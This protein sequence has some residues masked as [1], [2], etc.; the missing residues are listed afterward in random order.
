MNARA[1]APPP[2]LSRIRTR[3][4]TI[5]VL[6]SGVAAALGMAD[7]A[8]FYQ[9]YLLAF[10]YWFGIALG[11]L[12][13]LMVQHLTGGAWGVV[14]RRV[15]EAATRTLPLLAVMFVP[16]AFGL[17]YL[18]PWTDTE[19]VLAD[20]VLRQKMAYLN[21]PFFLARAA[22]YFVVWLG[23]ATLL[24]RW[25]NGQ[26]ETGD[27][28]F[29][30]RMRKLSGAGLI[31]WGATITFASIDW[32]M[33]LEPHWYS[34]IFGILMMGG[35]GLG[36]MAFSII[37]LRWLS[38]REPLAGVIKQAHFHDL[39]NLLMTFVVLWAYFS[40]SQLLIIWS[41]NLPEEIPWYLHRIEGGWAA[42]AI[43]VAVFYFAV[44]FILLLSRRT[45][46]RARSLAMVAGGVLAARLVDLFYLIAPEFSKQGF[47]FH[48]LDF[49]AVIGVGGLWV[50]FFTR[51]LGRRPLLPVNDPELESAIAPEHA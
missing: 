35:Q 5:G 24:S 31:L 50:A 4:L 13:L 17:S 41:G 3:A 8:Q 49:A 51:E 46:R 30:D 16:L 38:E 42:I 34:T 2:A 39:G 26:D 6:G 19:K 18:F 37:T 43:V 20:P 23:M 45:K 10:V 14:I 33:S 1:F 11:A 48:A 27:P 29:A 40:F 44:P 36:A 15:L 21:V 12:A 9:S 28:R 47:V 32:L 7:P 25:S 22:I